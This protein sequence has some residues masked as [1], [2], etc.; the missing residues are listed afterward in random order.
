MHIVRRC[1]GVTMAKPVATL[2][3]VRGG[4]G[5]EDTDWGPERSGGRF[6]MVTPKHRRTNSFLVVIDI[7]RLV[8]GDGVAE[9][10]VVAGIH[11]NLVELPAV[12][13]TD[14]VLLDDA[15]R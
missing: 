5:V 3:R 6:C 13:L 7:D 12:V 2:G 1:E 9:L 8:E 15:H 10:G 14:L 4:G 11:Q